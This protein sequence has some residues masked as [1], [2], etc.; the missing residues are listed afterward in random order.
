MA[1]ESEVERDRLVPCPDVAATASELVVR[2]RRV[3][4]IVEQIAGVPV[5]QIWDLIVEVTH[6]VPWEGADR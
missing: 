5:P 3:E 1:A 2:I 4:R 6:H